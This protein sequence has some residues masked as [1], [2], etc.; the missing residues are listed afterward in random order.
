MIRMT[1]LA[2]ALTLVAATPAGADLRPL[3]NAIRQV[4]S[5]GN[6]RAVGDAGKSKGPLQIQIGYWT[7]GGG[8]AEDYERMVWNVEASERIVLGYW[9]RYC[10]KAL[11]AGDLETLAR[12]HNGG[13]A[14]ARKRAT[15][16][17]WQRVE[18]DLAKGR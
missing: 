18:A 2:L 14:G 10:P 12:V 16:K 5:G 4:E 15:L 9:R 17:Y 1:M 6:N 3:L 7:D 11:A 8:K 13:P